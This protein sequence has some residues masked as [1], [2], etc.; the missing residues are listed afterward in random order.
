MS[1]ATSICEVEDQLL[2]LRLE[3]AR[4]TRDDAD[5]RANLASEQRSHVDFE[6]ATDVERVIASTGT[7]QWNAYFS[8]TPLDLGCASARWQ[9]E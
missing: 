3:Q 5:V 8:Q 9:H 6:L 7:Q 1:G 2:E 4:L